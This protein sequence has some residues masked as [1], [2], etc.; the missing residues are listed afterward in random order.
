M[1]IPES[2]GV[3]GREEILRDE[4]SDAN[5]MMAGR[6]VAADCEEHL[7]VLRAAIEKVAAAGPDERDAAVAEALVAARAAQ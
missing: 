4:E 3:P 6:A 2:G 5:A 1:A 7:R